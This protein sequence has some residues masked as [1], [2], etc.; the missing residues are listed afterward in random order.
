MIKPQVELILRTAQTDTGG[1]AVCRQFLLSLWDG[2]TYQCDLQALLYQDNAHFDACRVILTHLYTNNDQLE[3][4][5]TQEQID[6][7]RPL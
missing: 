5:I 3:S 4:F 1:A 6:T 7:I 2:G